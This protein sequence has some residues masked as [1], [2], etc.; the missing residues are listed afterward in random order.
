[1]SFAAMKYNLLYFKGADP[2]NC[3]GEDDKGEIWTVERGK[4]KTIQ[5]PPGF[6]GNYNDYQNLDWKK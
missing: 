1:M 3:N 5:C 4:S 6:I 2:D